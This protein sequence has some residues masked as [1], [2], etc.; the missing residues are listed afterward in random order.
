MKLRFPSGRRARHAVLILIDLVSLVVAI[1]LVFGIYPSS[2][3]RLTTQTKVIH[4]AILMGCIFLMRLLFRVYSQSWR[5]ANESAYL[6]FI[7]AD[8][9]GG[10]LYFL[11]SNTFMV[12]K[13]SAIHTLAVVAMSLIFTLTLRFLYQ[14]R[15][16]VDRSPFKISKLK[17]K[18][19]KLI[20]GPLQ[21]RIAIVGASEMGIQLARELLSDKN[22]KYLPVCFLDNHPGK[23]G[24][25][26]LNLRVYPEDESI[27]LTAQKM[28]VDTFVIT[29]PDKDAE[30]LQKLFVFYK[31]FGRNVLIYDFPADRLLD[32]GQSKTIR[33]INI[34]DL[35]PRKKI[36]N[37]GHN[38]G[39][40]Y[41][42]QTILVTGAGGSIGSELCRQLLVMEPDT[43]VLLDIY[44][45][46]VYDLQNELNARKSSVKVRVEI[47]SVRDK[48]KIDEVM[49]RYKPSFVFHAAAHKHV[50]L[51][52]HNP[53]EAIKNNV[54]GTYNLV[55][56]AEEHGVKRFI[57]I[58]TDKAVNPTNIM[59]ASKR[60]CE[61]I[62]QSRKDSQTAFVAVR[63]GNVLN[64]NGSVIPLFLN[65]IKAGGP[66]TV[67]DKRI[68]R[69]FMMISEAAQLVL[70]TGCRA[71]KG[72]IYVLNMG[73]QV[74]I[75]DLAENLIRLSGYIPYKEI[76][77]Q[78]IGLRPG[79]KL[80]EEILV[81]KTSQ[82]QTDDQRIFI[83][84]ESGLSREEVQE[85]LNLLKDALSSKAK[86]AL[87]EAVKKAVPTYHDAEEVNKEAI[88]QE[89]EKT[90][91]KEAL[92]EDA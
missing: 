11:I 52:E 32:D 40:Y 79:E 83:E 77:I 67:T 64:S 54:F 4:G 27:A 10:G 36:S 28:N 7:F 8:T 19:S 44:E 39:E 26:I 75:L 60:L 84:R 12:W 56:S 46:S 14:W 68:V 35:L 38:K 57:L 16:A 3:M 81:D 85:K 88:R 34:E 1:A 59:G 5:Y 78:E 41:K 82:L 89:E 37:L 86:D 18:N 42:G 47:A 72:D 24:N 21:T 23:I 33:E 17:D 49:D 50:P 92:K 70:Q 25:F 15:R 13:I 30:F 62:V 71:E 31:Q 20:D 63:F 61:M 65:Q 48:N 6:L 66:V 91:P 45:N 43:L 73:S 90:Q 55:T 22:A 29:I 53:E 58:S 69:Y 9:L 80:Y 87:V 51:M 76:D 2:A 74:K